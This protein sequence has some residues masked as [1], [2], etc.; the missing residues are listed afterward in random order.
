VSPLLC[1]GET[2][3][4]VEVHWTTGTPNGRG[5]SYHST[6]YCIQPDD[7]AVTPWVPPWLVEAAGILAVTGLA[8]AA[9]TV[10]RRRR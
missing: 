2:T 8:V 3:R 6:L 10:A 7:T 4:A 1:P 9:L 5:T